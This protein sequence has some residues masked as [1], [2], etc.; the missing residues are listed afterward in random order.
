VKAIKRV[1]QFRPDFRTRASINFLLGGALAPNGLYGS[2]V[3]AT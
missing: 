1:G 2:N 3:V